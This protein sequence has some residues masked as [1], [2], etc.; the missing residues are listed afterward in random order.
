MSQIAQERMPK[1]IIKAIIAGSIGNV[2]EWIDWSIYGVAAPIIAHQFFPSDNPTISLLQAFGV[3]AIGFLIR[4]FGAMVLGPYGDKC[5]RNKC[6]ALSIILMALGTGVLGIL[7]TY[8]TIGV[9]API[10]LLVCRL[11]QGFATGGEWGSATSFIYELAP[12]HRRAFV[13]SFRPTG[14]GL[15]FFLGSFAV[16][17]TTMLFSTE[18]IN[19][20]AWRVPFFFGF[21][22][23]L[24]GLYIR[25]HVDESPEFLKAKAN[26]ETSETP[27]SDSVKN[28]K[29]GLVVVFAL[30]L[31]WNVVYYILFTYMPTYLKTV[32]GIPYDVAMKMASAATL[33]Y[34]ILLPILG[35]FADKANKKMMLSV[36]CLGY[37]FLTYPA[38]LLMR[39]A[40]QPTI[41]ITLILL[42]GF[43]SF[44]SAALP[45]VLAEQF[46]TRTRNTA[47]S[48]SYTLNATL[49]GGT[50]PLLSTW[51]ASVT[52]NPIAPG[53]YMILCTIL[54]YLAVYW[55][56][57][58]EKRQP[59]KTAEQAAS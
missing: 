13:S 53:F 26:N 22:V 34:T 4:P 1:G 17:M 56:V 57:T 40:H 7:P 36:S 20:W 9:L 35:W 55:G 46:P 16:T 10:L 44:Y 21:L 19:A 58:N 2:V 33:F 30:S 45:V 41:W 11:I 5:G 54:S 3:F 32:I 37:I 50:A 47:I 38:F 31:V 43:M 52:G 25:M 23:G 28:D 12:P 59:L 18:T 49:F 48:I 14:T 27:L 6:L 51:L 42:A 8:Q 24:V 29:K 39:S 15:G